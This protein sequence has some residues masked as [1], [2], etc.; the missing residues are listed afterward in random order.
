MGLEIVGDGEGEDEDGKS[1]EGDS[2]QVDDGPGAVRSLYSALQVWN[3]R[4]KI[5]VPSA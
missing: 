5:D 2:V 3:V 4:M 1:D